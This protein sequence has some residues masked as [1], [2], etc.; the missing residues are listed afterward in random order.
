LLSRRWPIER[1]GICKRLQSRVDAI[2]CIA[3]IKRSEEMNI[4][5]LI[6]A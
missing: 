2:V 3:R 6:A 5:A 4:A 1:F